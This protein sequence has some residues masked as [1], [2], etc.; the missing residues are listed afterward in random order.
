MRGEL[1]RKLGYK[2]SDR[3]LLGSLYDIFMR[4]VRYKAEPLRFNYNVLIG[5]K[6]RML[7]YRMLKKKFFSEAVKERPW[8]SIPK[9]ANP[10][11]IW[12]LWIQ[13][14]ETHRSLSGAVMNLFNSSFRITGSLCSQKKTSVSTRSFRI[15]SRRSTAK[16]SY[17]MMRYS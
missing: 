10:K 4:N 11:T 6:H 12:F 15:L 8:E 17:P 2:I 1:L 13:G 14:M 9:E 16:A 7:Y 5:Q 3:M